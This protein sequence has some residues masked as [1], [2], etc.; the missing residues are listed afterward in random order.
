MF[1]AVMPDSREVIAQRQREVLLIALRVFGGLE[2]YAMHSTNFSLQPAGVQGSATCW[3]LE[4]LPSDLKRLRGSGQSPKFGVFD[5]NGY[6]PTPE[7]FLFRWSPQ[8][9]LSWPTRIVSGIERLQLCHWRAPR[10]LERRLFSWTINQDLLDLDQGL[11]QTFR[12]APLAVRNE[13]QAKAAL[14]RVITGWEQPQK[15]RRFLSAS[16]QSEVV[17]RFKSCRDWFPKT[18]KVLEQVELADD[19]DRAQLMA[20]AL[21]KLKAESLILSALPSELGDLSADGRRRFRR[22]VRNLEKRTDH[23]DRKLA[24]LWSFLGDRNCDQIHEFLKTLGL[25]HG[26]LPKSL[27]RR[28]QRLGLFSRVKTGPSPRYADEA[29][30]A[31][32]FPLQISGA[33]GFELQSFPERYVMRR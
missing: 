28:H 1:L 23:L 31:E 16:E 29:L 9:Q 11:V 15:V 25:G 17:A 13:S 18:V 3:S 19:K 24:D 14:A 8:L 26:L 33:L 22:M 7:I 2:Y 30:D 4:V 10:E 32:S 6:F 27:R 21:T 5:L 12:S 20:H